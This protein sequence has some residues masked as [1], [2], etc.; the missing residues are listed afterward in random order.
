MKRIH[1]LLIIAIAALAF[2]SI[3]YF[4]AEMGSPEPAG[5]TETGTST[6]AENRN[7]Y[8]RNTNE[9][10]SVSRHNAITK[11]VEEVSPA[12][13]GINVIS[14]QRVVQRNPLS[15]FFNDSFSRQ[16]FQDKY[17]DKYV[18]GLGSGFLISPDGFIL[19]NSHVVQNAKEIVV[20]MTNGD[21]YNALPI[22]RDYITDIALLKIDGKDLPYCR[23]G[24]SDELLVGEWVISFGNPFGLFDYNNKP[25]VTVGVVSALDRD[26]GL[27][28]GRVYKDMIQTDASMNPGNSGGPLVNADGEV[29]GMNSFI[30][31]GG[32]YSEG[33]IGLGFAIPVNKVINVK[34][35]LAANGEVKREFWHG[36]HLKLLSRYWSRILNINKD[37]AIVQSIEK[38]S[39]AETAGIKRM[40]VLISINGN[41][42]SSYITGETIKQ[43]ILDVYVKSNGLQNGDRVELVFIR[44]E[45]RYRATIMLAMPPK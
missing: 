27:Q 14:V 6:A 39:P 43:N 2:Y 31:T 45:Q 36:I 26:F 18:K 7:Q 35:E 20:T 28:E 41:D 38:N 23:L 37:C 19:T 40:D 29:I 8:K 21:K 5:E 1:L 9:E 44:D 32:K 3:Q 24:N 11:A 22:G 42:L 12:V 15:S 25:A 30:F 33:S 34:E 17:Y 10:V 4:R 16:F 13:V